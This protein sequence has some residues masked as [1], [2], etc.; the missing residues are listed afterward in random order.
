FDSTDPQA[1]VRAAAG[2]ASDLMVFMTYSAP[3]TDAFSL[4]GSVKFI[5]RSLTGA[6]P[7]SFAVDPVTGDAVP[8]RSLDFQASGLGADLG[9]LWENLDRTMAFGGSVQNMGTIG[10]F[11]QGFSLDLGG[12]EVLPTTFR[13]GS[14]WR[15]GLWG[16]KLLVTG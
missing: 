9:V 16:Q 13:L 7:A 11:G 14:A 8:T 1:L 4:G 6:D 3:L 10:R 5:R 12:G 2:A 15:T